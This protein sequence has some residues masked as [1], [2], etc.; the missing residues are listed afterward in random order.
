MKQMTIKEEKVR[1]ALLT[2]AYTDFSKL[3]KAHSFYKVPDRTMSED[4]VQITFKKTWNYLVKG[5][6]ILLMKAFLFRILNDLIVD[7]Y[8]KRKTI[9]L[10][11]LLEKGFQPST[12]SSERLVNVL[13]GKA[14][15]LLIGSLPLSYQK[16]MRLRYVQDLT[17]LEI[18]LITGMS[19]NTVAVRLHRGLKKLRVIYYAQ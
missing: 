14:A 2:D 12:N 5:G 15:I 13:D 19:K 9:S 17:L 4:L 18:S 11:S 8:R 6:N 1:K 16:V 10:D 3:L 7:E